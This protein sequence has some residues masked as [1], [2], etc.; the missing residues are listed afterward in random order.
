[1]KNT[2]I[3]ILLA[4]LVLYGQLSYS[5]GYSLQQCID[6]AWKNN[7]VLKQSE[8]SAEISKSN[9]TR[10]KAGLLPSLNGG[11]THTYNIGR[12]I[13]RYTNTFANSTVL[14]QNFFLS[15]QVTLWSGMAQY[16]TIRSNEYAYLSSRETYE[17]Q[18]NDIAL[19]VASAFMQVMY[20]EEFMKIQELQVK[21][22]QLQVERTQKLL[23]AGAVA[24]GNLY[25][26]KAQLASEEFNYT[27][28]QN[29]YKLSLLT[30]Q[31][32][33]NLD[34]LN[35]FS[36]E[37]PNLEINAA[38]LLAYKPAD[39]YQNALKT[40]HNI[41]S[42]EYRMKSNEKSL[43]AARGGIS[44]TLSF[45]AS[46]GTGY[47]GLAK[48]IQSFDFKGF[49]AF[50]I[51]SQLDTVYQP[52][53]E[54]KTSP[55]P[56]NKQ[57]KNNVNKS[58]G[59]TLQIPLFNGYQTGTQ[60]RQ[61]KL[62]MLSSK[63]NYDN[64]KQQLFKTITQAYADAQAS[65]NKYASAKTAFEAASESYN[66]TEQK[67]NLGAISVY[68]YNNAKL[69]LM[70]AETDLLTSKYDFVFKIKVLDFYQGKPLSF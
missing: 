55:T 26:I 46:I 10:S 44:P 51:T 7:L 63:Y 11:A 52:V 14:S 13:D 69:R 15:S 56:W 31:Q 37:K 33:L 4:A 2:R 43:S 65:L 30:L 38:D 70:R 35:N 53:Y 64:T 1:M 36:I 66:Y 48:D 62:Q 68:E 20:N 59:F 42:A 58:L 18:K 12:T 27:T 21:M 29:N 60:I 40:Q 34:T 8:I 47:S 32:L 23:D 24:K 9:V 25:D 6:I 3:I 17:Q 61:S 57:M 50:G 41:K 67:F 49:Q 54:A 19:N 39:I 45:N 16:N 22:T 28:A 5:Q